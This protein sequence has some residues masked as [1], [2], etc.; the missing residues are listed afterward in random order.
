MKHHSIL[1]APFITTALVA[2]QFPVVPVNAQEAPTRAQANEAL[3]KAVKFFRDKVSIDGA[4]LWRY[5]EDLSLR[6]GEEKATATQAW[7]QPPGTPSVGEACLTAYERTK[8]KYLLDAAIHAARA[9]VKGQLHS[10]GWEHNMEFDPAARQRYAYRVDG[11]LRPNTRNNTSLD[12][13]K[14]QSAIQ[15]MMHIDRA[16]GFK[17][18][19]IHEATQYALEGLLKAQFP[20][21]AWSQ[22]FSGPPKPEDFPVVKANYPESWSRTFPGVRYASFYT[23]NDNALADAMA[24]CFE[25][26]DIYNEPRYKDAAK[27]GG[28]FLIL[29]QMPEPQPAWAQQYNVQM[30]PAWARKFEPPSITGG[31]S[32]GAIRI[33]MAVYRETGDKKYLEP[34]PR[35]LAYLKKSELPNGRMPRFLELKTNRPLYFNLNY[36]LVYTSDNMPTHY[37]FITS[38]SVDRLQSDYEKLLATDPS[39][40]KPAPKPETYELSSS[41]AASARQAIASLDDRGAWVENG[42]LRDSDPDRKF[43]RVITTQTFIRNL[44]TLS[45]FMAANK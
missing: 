9:L 36:E 21:G 43:S 5:S 25:A 44:D 39:K 15:F 1:T 29:A 8:E 41:L 42:R 2:L 23:L 12:D 27:R 3:Q 26:A 45:R 38:S 6:E 28:D 19:Q 16:L 31:E 35:A 4:Y 22:Q 32:Q 18:A 10:G 24:T 33:L 7:V 37:A 11:P 14:T 17:D 34:I 40:L 13:K 30:Q 20:N